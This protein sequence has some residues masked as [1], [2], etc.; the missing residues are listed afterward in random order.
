M[1]ADVG[2]GHS[3][4]LAVNLL[5]LNLPNISEVILKNREVL[6]DR[7]TKV[8]TFDETLGSRHID[9]YA[10]AFHK[11][12]GF[13][14][15][16]GFAV[17]DEDSAA[18][19]ERAQART[20][21]LRAVR[22]I[23]RGDSA[24][25]SLLVAD[26][27]DAAQLERHQIAKIKAFLEEGFPNIRIVLNLM[28]HDLLA[29]CAYDKALKTGTALPLSDWA[30]TMLQRKY[31]R[32]DQLLETWSSVFDEES[33]YINAM[34]SGADVS[35]SAVTILKDLFSLGDDRLSR[36]APQPPTAIMQPLAQKFLLYLNTAAEDAAD[37]SN[38][39]SL[40]GLHSYLECNYS[41]PARNHLTRKDY[42]MLDKLAESN[43]RFQ[44]RWATDRPDLFK[45][46]R[47]DLPREPQ[48]AE[49]TMAVAQ[50]FAKFM[51]DIGTRIVEGEQEANRTKGN[52]P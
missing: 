37:D 10:Y 9:T 17:R 4:I 33:I 32:Y 6:L 39:V 50:I 18:P 19:Q 48:E 21:L 45:C 16:R 47:E 49:D 22:A 44:G 34:E 25:S 11:N 38:G 2:T 40:D 20:T 35:A 14:S 8:Y 27:H 28:R 31:L 7:R 12:W 1:V 52:H 26:I 36:I 23:R 29:S 24:Q 43:A 15:S 51:E 5:G 46:R 30:R 41:E 3:C 13:D 42:R